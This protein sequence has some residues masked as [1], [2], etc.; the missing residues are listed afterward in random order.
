[1][2]GISC[3]EQVK[4]CDMVA[5]RNISLEIIAL[6]FGLTFFVLSFFVKG[7]IKQWLPY[8]IILIILAVGLYNG[9]KYT[10]YSPA[11]SFYPADS[12]ISE[13]QTLTNG[14]T[15]GFGSASIST[16][17]QT[18]FKFYSAQYYHP[19]YVRR[20]GELV[21]Y[22]NSESITANLMRSDVQIING[23]DLPKD[24]RVRRRR[25][26]D[27]LGIKYVRYKKSE[28]PKMVPYKNIV[29]Q[30]KDWIIYRNDGAV[31]RMYFVS[32]YKVFNSDDKLLD[33][34]FSASFKPK[35]MA[36]LE[37]NPDVTLQSSK[38]QILSESFSESN[39]EAKV[40]T[41][42]TGL[43]VV[44]DDYYSGWKAYIDGKETPIL[45]TNY[46]FRSIIVPAGTH[47]IK[48]IDDPFAFTAGLYITLVI[49]ILYLMFISWVL[50]KQLRSML[51]LK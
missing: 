1:M 28:L 24:D 35:E 41:E 39:L 34:M 46:T 36:A 20:Y 18:Y 4:A 37:V 31:S 19:L 26:L 15:F 40:Y 14:R 11:S 22:G 6:M 12:L 8:G 25:L 50:R 49:G 21:S 17:L 48:M 9:W 33:Y 29:W 30:D 10:P 43:L 16:D 2:L 42:K 45:R 38:S 13:L 47:D 27:L 5:F 44:N 23:I 51:K 32:S 3:S 7:K